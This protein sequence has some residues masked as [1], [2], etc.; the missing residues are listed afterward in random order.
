MTEYDDLFQIYG[1]LLLNKVNCISNLDDNSNNF[2]YF[3]MSNSANIICFFVI[4]FFELNNF[5]VTLSE[6]FLIF[7]YD[8]FDIL[9]LRDFDI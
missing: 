1:L 9:K 2:L 3:I 7:S 8:S 5:E 4:S 6:R